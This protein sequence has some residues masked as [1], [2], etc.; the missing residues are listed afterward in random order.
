MSARNAESMEFFLFVPQIRTTFERLVATALAA[1]QA[2]FVGMVG[3]DHIEAPGAVGQ[4]TFEA[5]TVNT[6]IAAR[7]SRL[8]VGSLIGCDA[9]RHP[10]LLAH[11]A[12]TINHASGGRFELGIGWGSWTPDFEK[13]GV[14]PDQPRDRVERMGETLDVLRLLWSGESADYDGRFHKLR[15]AVL[16]PKPLGRI[17]ILIGGS[18]PKTL[19]LVREHADWWNLDTRYADRMHGAEYDELRAQIGEARISV[20]QKIGHVT[21]GASHDEVSEKAKRRF[22]RKGVRLGTGGELVDYFAELAG[23]GVERVYAWMADHS[24]PG[25]LEQF[26]EEVIAPL[27][28]GG[29]RM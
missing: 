23:R 5:T 28:G 25:A 10:A 13:F 27:G 6:W 21:R 22:G 4:P 26:G 7:T 11:H 9:F 14:E 12:A 29:R 15:G 16:A 24:K 20:Q 3:M 19:A 18:G 8:K 2:G 1:E 17:P